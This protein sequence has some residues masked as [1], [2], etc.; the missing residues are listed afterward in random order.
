[1]F[2]GSDLRG[3]L[4]REQV[5]DNAT[6]PLCSLSAAAASREPFPPRA[7][8]LHFLKENMPIKLYVG[9]LSFSTTAQQLEDLFAQSG[10]VESARIA[11]N[12]DRGRSRG[13][14][15]VEMTTSEEAL[16]AIQALDGQD[17]DGH[18]L[19][20]NQV[21]PKEDRRGHTGFGS[22]R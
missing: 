21:R 19:K 3:Q 15:F 8:L 7:R 17:V 11:T 4:L 12:R 16:A 22:G 1:L 10:K 2:V 9:N 6:K 13:F 20:V 14:A 18:M 5:N